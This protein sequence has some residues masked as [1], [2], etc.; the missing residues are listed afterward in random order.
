M[1]SRKHPYKDMEC[2]KDMSKL[3]WDEFHDIT[4]NGMIVI[5]HDEMTTVFINLIADFNKM[6]RM[7]AEGVI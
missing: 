3:V 1:K 7:Q 4:R 2:W 6:K 5:S